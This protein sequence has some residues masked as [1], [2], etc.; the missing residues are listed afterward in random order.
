MSVHKWE[1][2]KSIDGQK[3][4]TLLEVLIAILVLS[5]GLLG[6]A[7]LQINALQS[8]YY[9]YQVSVANLAVKDVR[10][11][12]W[13]S[14]LEFPF[15]DSA[16]V[17]CPSGELSDGLPVDERFSSIV[18]GAND[19]WGGKLPEGIIAIDNFEPC[20][21]IISIHWLDEKFGDEEPPND[22][23]LDGRYSTLTYHMKA[24]G[25]VYEGN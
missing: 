20:S 18:S 21:Y 10:E 16:Y 19:Y 7:A 2:C 1:R 24:P 3:G 6:L 8:S 23:A 12:L 22:E 25:Y 17:M 11:R 13:E 14:L 9:S 15:E 4:F 5:I